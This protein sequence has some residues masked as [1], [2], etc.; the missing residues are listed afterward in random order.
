MAN[1][2]AKRSVSPLRE[3]AGIPRPVLLVKPSYGVVQPGEDIRRVAQRLSGDANKWPE[4]MAANTGVLRFGAIPEGADVA[5]PLELEA[6]TRLFVPATWQNTQAGA[7]PTD[8]EGSINLAQ[9]VGAA[10]AA[11]YGK[12]KGSDAD[13]GAAWR[14]IGQ[15]ILAWYPYLPG[16]PGAPAMP[17]VTDLTS[18]TAKAVVDYVV[19]LVESAV[20]YLKAGGTPLAATQVPWGA[21]PF[22]NVPWSQIAEEFPDDQAA[23][24]KFFRAATTPPVQYRPVAPGGGFAERPAPTQPQWPESPQWPETPSFPA[25]TPY[26]PFRPQQRVPVATSAEQ[27]RQRLTPPAAESVSDAVRRERPLDML[28]AGGASPLNLA[29]TNWSD[30][31]QVNWQDVP[32]GSVFWSFFSDPQVMKCAYAN[33]GRLRAM[34]DCSDCYEGGDAEYFKLVLCDLSIDPCACHPAPPGPEPP[35]PGP[36]P[37]GPTPGTE[38]PNW[39]CTPFPDCLA[40]PGNWPASVPKPCEVFPGC[41]PEWIKSQ[42]GQVP[43]EPQPEKKT[44]NTLWWVIGG[45]VVLTLIVGTVAVAASR[46]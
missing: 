12:A 39:S 40:Q 28:G 3:N 27:A 2:T 41:I 29:Q 14:D 9:W 20:R 19:A 16:Q 34:Y 11:V 35:G 8:L 33:P 45:G 42:G 7:T 30:F 23:F 1:M 38:M 15:V 5:V 17:P 22:D 6:G 46:S 24:W 37:P 25:P 21:V 18:A 43:G 4:L 31:T 36:E 44:D 26:Y 10:L 13:P 32:W